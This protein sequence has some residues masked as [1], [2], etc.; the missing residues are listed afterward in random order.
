MDFI[1]NIVNKKSNRYSNVF[2]ENKMERR[3]FKGVGTN[4][5]KSIVFLYNVPKDDS[6]EFII[7]VF[8]CEVQNTGSYK[9]YFD[10]PGSINYL[11]SPEIKDFNDDE[12]FEEVLKE[13]S[14]QAA[15]LNKYA[16]E[17]F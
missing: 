16:M 2:I 3:G 11:K 1:N 7:P 10:I 8:K 15:I 9:F 4:E 13:F 6:M 17:G 14:K 12:K 5:G